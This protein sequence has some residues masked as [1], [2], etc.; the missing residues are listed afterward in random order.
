MTKTCISCGMPM[1]KPVDYP[2][3][4]T[5]KDYCV[6]CAR[7]DGSMQSFEEKRISMAEFIM[8]TQG[9]DDAAA[10]RA[11]EAHMRKQPAW[12]EC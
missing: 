7:A 3:G 2:N 12:R 8:R 10:L 6:H 4:D 5:T 11:A 1:T 9:L